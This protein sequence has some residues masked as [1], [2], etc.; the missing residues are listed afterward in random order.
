[1][2]RKEGGSG[3][4]VEHFSDCLVLMICSP[5]GIENW[6]K[7]VTNICL[8][9]CVYKGEVLGDWERTNIFS[10]KE[11]GENYSPAP[12]MSNATA[13]WDVYTSSFKAL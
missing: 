1:M 5:R 3:W 8:R 6:P 10:E 13:T 11:E 7:L 9:Q 2:S 12:L 4:R